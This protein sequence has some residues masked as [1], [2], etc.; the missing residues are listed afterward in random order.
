L[1]V[2]A[3]L[4]SGARKGPPATAV[5]REMDVG[6]GEEGWVGGSLWRALRAGSTRH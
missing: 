4:R 6:R 3:H 2:H 1:L 5:E